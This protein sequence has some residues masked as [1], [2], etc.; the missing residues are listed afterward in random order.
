MEVDNRFVANELFYKSLSHNPS[1][2]RLIMTKVVDS[3]IPKNIRLEVSSTALSK[4]IAT[5]QICL[6]DFRCL[7][8]ASKAQV[9]KLCIKS[10]SF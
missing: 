3:A 5:G 2:K 10:I 9:R 4:L 7:D 8:T 1:S 6:E